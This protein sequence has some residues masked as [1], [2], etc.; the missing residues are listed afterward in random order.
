MTENAYVRNLRRLTRA[1]PSAEHA[2]AIERELYASGSDRASVV[3]FGSYVETILER[4][5]TKAVRDDLNSEDRKQLFEYEGAAGTFSAKIIV[6]YAFKLIG[7]M[8]RS[9]LTLIRLLRNEFA[10]SLMPIG[11]DTPE[12]HDVCKQFKIIDLPDSWI[13]DEYLIRVAGLDRAAARDRNHPKT[14][15]FTTCNE[16]AVRMDVARH[17][18]REG[19][20]IY[21]NDDPVP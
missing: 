4:L 18:F 15:F 2:D 19:D 10:H 5:L 7:P 14:R 12:V 6:A 11:F 13:N 16:I 17:G 9:D 21:T 20:R 8:M 1:D 3:M